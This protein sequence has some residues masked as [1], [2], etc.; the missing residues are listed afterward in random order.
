MAVFLSEDWIE[1]GRRLGA[2]EP[3]RPGLNAS[4]QFLVGG[5]PGGDVSYWWRIQDGRLVDAALGQLEDS[6]VS[7]TY[8]Y[9]DAVLVQRGQ[10]DA[11]AAFM[12]GRAKVA[13]HLT[14]LMSVLPL[15]AS[16]DYKDLQGRI[17]D[18]TEYAE[19]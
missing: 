5:G 7:I 2:G 13:G 11:N 6:D 9:P 4:V 10:L 19:E 12:Q 8:T 3:E 17:A 18:Q 1:L 16:A 15:T 14:K